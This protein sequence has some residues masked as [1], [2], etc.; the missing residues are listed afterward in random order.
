MAAAL[1][2]AATLLGKV[3][4]MLSA[5]PVAA[6]VD[7]LELGHNSE[8]IKA[9]LAH[10]R[11]LLHN[12]QVSDAGHNPGLQDLLPALS[13]NAD[14]AEDLLDELHY[15]QIHDK[16]HGTSIATTQPNSL[17]H[18]RNALRHT[19]TSWA[20]CFSCSS[21]QDDDSDSASADDAHTLH[22]QPVTMSRKIKSV[23]QDMQTQ[24]DSISD[25]LSSIPSS[26]MAVALLHR[27]QIGSTIMQDTLYGRRDTFEETV[28]RIIGC[29]PTV[30]V[31]PIVGPGGI[32]KTTFTQHLYND[33]R[34]YNDTR[35]EN[36]FEVRVWV[37][38]STD[39]DV[40]KLTREILGCI[41]ATQEEGSSGAANETLNLDQLQ[42][43]I[44]RRLKSRR[45]LI[46][47]DDIWKCDGEN[48]WKTLLAPFTKGETKG[49]MVLVTTR[50]P[51]VACMVKTVDPL[52]LR[53]L[54]AND[55]FTFFEACIFGDF[56]P[57][58]YDDE[59]VDIAAKI[60]NKLKGSP[61]A[62]K[63][64][65]RLLRRDFSRKHWDGVL[66]KHEWLSMENN[67]DIM[68]CLKIS[69]DYLPFDLRKCFSYFGLF[70]E[71][72]RFGNSEMNHLFAAV[73]I[74]D[75]THQVDR[76]YLE[77][78]VDNGFL[79]KEVDYPGQNKY[80]LHDLMHQL[81]RSVSAQEC[82]NICDFDFRA[83]AIPQSVRHLSI[84]IEDGYDENFEEEMCK[85][86]GRID[87]S[88]LRTL[89]ILRSYK[90]KFMK[91]LNDSFKEINSL[92]VLFIVVN[93][94]E[95]F[96]HRFSKLIHLQYLKISSPYSD[97]ELCLPS[98]LSRFYHLKFLDLDNWHGC[99]NLPEDFSHLENLHDFH[100]KS[101]LYSN[102]RNVGKIKHLRRLRE[103]CV[104]KESMGFELRELGG[105]ANLEEE[106]IISGLEHVETKEEATAAKLV[107]KMNL[108]ELTLLWDRDRRT[109]DTDILDSLQPHSNLRVLTIANPGGTICPS[110]LSLA[111]WLET[112]WLEGVSWSTLPPFGKIPNLKVLTLKRISGML[113]FGPHCGGAPG[114]CFMRLKKVEFLELPALA[115]WVVEP[116][117]HSFPSLEIIRCVKCPNL[118]MMPFSEVSCTN[119]CTLKVSGCP[120]MSLRSMPHTSTLTDLVINEKELTYDGKKLGASGYGGALAFN[121]L[122]KVEYMTI[123]AVGRCDGLFPEELDPS[124]VFRSVNSLSLDVSHLTSKSASKVLN[125]FTALSVLLIYAHFADDDYEEC[126]M[127]FPLSSS[128]Q[129]LSFTDCKGLVLVP[130]ENGGGI[131]ED[132]SSLQSLKIYSCGEFF[133]R[134]PMG[135][136]DGAQTTYPFP[137]SLRELHVW[138]EPSMKSMALLSNL[139]S[140]TSLSLTDCSNLTVDGFNPLTAVNL[141]KLEVH[142]SNTV[143][144]DLLSEVARTKLLTAGY[145]SRLEELTV[146]D[147]S[148]LLVGPICNLLAPSL[149]TLE[150]WFDER[151]ESFSEEQEEALQLLTSLQ[152]VDFCVCLG[153]QSLPQ[154]LHRLS[155][156]K[157]LSVRSCP[158]IQSIP[159]EGFPVSLRKLLIDSH[160]LEINEQIERMKRTNPDLS[161]EFV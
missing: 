46:V 79:M 56:K 62:A 111:I 113:Q 24:C 9:K 125:C 55:F 72:H 110:W 117:C 15:F 47:L 123:E 12:A 115:K 22:F 48:Q 75:S 121:N 118:H 3:F 124:I 130:V 91:L 84:T 83:D 127:Q 87:I 78:L 30:S 132:R 4:T 95:S 14:Q 141:K 57:Q 156:L 49:S 145:I 101:E 104:K 151:V 150:F 60:A 44:A 153:L 74:A 119:L 114:K 32:G 88:N 63:T 8:Q 131:Q 1:G 106:L 68:P 58:D 157:Q 89:M 108:K 11:G 18:G 148:G 147:I 133:S 86:R 82:L 54:E 25:L 51:K 81:C 6:Y 126:V 26:S 76:N 138:D 100:A 142:N 61:L 39:F 161:V 98:T 59:L 43:S 19:T 93:S 140:L 33:A 80:V 41:I 50:F 21:A 29:K 146:D 77:E 42:L 155:S 144:A 154:G 28:N 27:P 13:R 158:K 52:E 40:L 70:P 116:N 94:P 23:L 137:A 90:K 36:H 35:A 71:D 67:D 134:W 92:R 135:D 120:K 53:G 99:S 37:C 64:V 102:I 31:L 34:L 20:A 128:L 159:M 65:G 10:T 149:H 160:L 73:G 66:K 7:S 16:L 97:S 5:A 96:P 139:T 103:F 136:V 85:L 152:N 143:A 129:D 17:R 122:D 69:Y 38:V 2:P 107:L 105:L 109:I 45:F 112:L